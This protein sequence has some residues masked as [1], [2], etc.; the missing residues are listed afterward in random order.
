LTFRGTVGSITGALAPMTTGFIVQ[1]THSFIP[2][3]LTASVI[4]TVS[5]LLCLGLVKQPV[6]ID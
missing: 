5:A 4:G 6:A 1:S 2:A 3:L